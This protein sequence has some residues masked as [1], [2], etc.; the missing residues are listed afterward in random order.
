MS[1]VMTSLPSRVLIKV[2]MEVLMISIKE[3]NR[4]ISWRR[5]EFIESS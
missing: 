4:A 3:L 2:R 5:T 1:A